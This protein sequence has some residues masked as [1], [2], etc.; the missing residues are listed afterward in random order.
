[1]LH[2]WRIFPL[3]CLQFAHHVSAF[4]RNSA[5]KPHLFCTDTLFDRSF[6]AVR[7]CISFKFEFCCFFL[8]ELSAALLAIRLVSSVSPIVSRDVPECGGATFPWEISNWASSPPVSPCFN[9]SFL[10]VF[11]IFGLHL[12]FNHSFL[13]VFS[14]FG[15]HL[16]WLVPHFNH[17]HFVPADYRLQNVGGCGSFTMVEDIWNP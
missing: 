3:S 9:H 8:S 11:S 5:F 6:L 7:D 1:L 17:A 10:F 14:N 13:F 2:S 16:S 15:L 12:S 4:L